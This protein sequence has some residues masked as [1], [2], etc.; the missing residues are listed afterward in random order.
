MK[1][2]NLT[3]EDYELRKEVQ[4]SNKTD[5]KEHFHGARKKLYVYN[6]MIG[7]TV[8]S[9][10]LDL[11]ELNKQQFAAFI[12]L[13]N[14]NLYRTFVK[15]PDL[16][17]LDVSFKGLSRNKNFDL[18]NDLDTGQIFWNI[19]LSSAYFQMALRLGYISQNFYNKYILDDRYKAVKRL[20]ISFLGRRN[21]M[22]YNTSNGKQVIE[23]D[24]SSLAQ[25]YKNIRNELYNVINNISQHTE[26]LEFN[27]DGISVLPAELKLVKDYFDSLGLIY[28]STRCKK[29]DS[30]VY[31]Y[32]STQKRFKRVINNKNK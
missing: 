5:Y 28:K 26:Y 22:I 19:D 27:I 14:R 15:K 20:C 16:H 1:S 7:S 8:L 18:Y 25:V 23:C 11:G 17:Y 12:G 24:M 30:Y 2:Y 3:L 10:S 9:A 6:K 31:S 13:F 32:G 4:V 29:I 21:K